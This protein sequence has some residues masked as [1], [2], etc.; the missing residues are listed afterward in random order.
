MKVEGGG[1]YLR[2]VNDGAR[3]VNKNYEIRDIFEDTTYPSKTTMLL[4]STMQIKA[5]QSFQMRYCVRVFV[6]GHQNC[7]TSKLK[8]PK[9]FISIK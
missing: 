8:S 9:K 6:K 1:H 7:Q 3:T 4:T 2:A 5:D